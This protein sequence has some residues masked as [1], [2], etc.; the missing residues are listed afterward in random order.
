MTTVLIVVAHP[1]DA[2]IAMAMRILDYTQSG[3]R[4]RVHAL[5]T[6]HT[7]SGTDLRRQ[8]CLAA[9][10]LLGISDYTFSQI[11]DSRFTSHRAQINAELF[12]VMRRDRPD[13]VYTHFPADQHLDHTV[14]SAEVTAVALREAANLTYFR[15]PYS[16]GF[17]PNEIFMGT[18]EHLQAKVAAL[19]CFTSQQQIDMATFTSLA[20]NQ[21]RQH[22]HHRVLERLPAEAHASELFSIARRLEFR[23]A[24]AS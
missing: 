6:G 1:D 15:S 7:G 13:I 9:G 10:A 22:V 5:T 12:T 20:R 2:E 24:T 8:E 21:Y 17:E 19:A 14:T 23:P 4:V 18:A 3:D 11:P 16:T